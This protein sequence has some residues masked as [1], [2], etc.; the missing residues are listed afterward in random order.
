[1]ELPFEAKRVHAWHELKQNAEIGNV[2]LG[3][4]LLSPFVYK[5]LSVPK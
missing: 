1:M 4:I 5:P 3:L 2:K